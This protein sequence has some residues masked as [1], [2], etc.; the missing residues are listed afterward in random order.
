VLNFQ[1]ATLALGRGAHSCLVEVERYAGPLSDVPA[2][3]QPPMTAADQ[4]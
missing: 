2:F 4:S 3:R 1:R